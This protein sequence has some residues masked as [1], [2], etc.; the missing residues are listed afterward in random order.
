MKARR[1]V[2]TIECESDAPIADLRRSTRVTLKN[3][4]GL[5]AGVVEQIQVNSIVPKAKPKGKRYRPQ[6]MV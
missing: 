5:F 4:M 3:P 6:A 1:L 2:I